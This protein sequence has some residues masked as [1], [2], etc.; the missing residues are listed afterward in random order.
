M[1]NTL[2]AVL[3][4]ILGRSL[5]VLKKRMIMPSLVNG[6]YSTDA[7]EFGDTIDV[8]IPTAVG[9]RNV[10]PS[11]T[12]PA[13]VDRTPTKV[14]IPLNNWKQ[15]DPIHLTD[16]EL[17]EI[18]RSKHFLPTSM[19]EAVKALAEDV[20]SDILAEYTG[21]YGYVGNAGTTPFATVAAGDITGARKVLN[22]QLAPRGL[23]RMVIDADA[24][25]AALELADFSS[26][27]RAASD[28][29]IKEGEIGR[30]FGFD[31]FY[32]DQ[33]PTHTTTGGGT[34]LVNDA[35]H[36]AGVNTITFDGGGTA[37]AVGDVFTVAGDTQTYVVSS[38]TATVITHE[39]AG[40]VALADNAAITFKASHVV[41]LAF[42]RD[43]FAFATRFLS[44]PQLEGAAGV[45]GVSRMQD[46]D[47]GLVLRLQVTRQHFQWAWEFDVLWGA[48]LVRPELACR[49]AG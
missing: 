14:Q 39:P 33:V 29:T 6:D 19:E 8:E 27:D 31:W 2:T 44:D 45:G 16:K 42:H 30:K 35:S 46:P 10:A 11:N 48:K 24:E 12:P 40:K 17:F 1:A 9:T 49:I 21:V 20:N 23:R 15:N 43:A 13:S 32:D 5:M 4:K 36:A 37:P 47:T 28:I 25:A 34:I 41:N 3:P 22:Q 38:S 26:A 7:K 18:D